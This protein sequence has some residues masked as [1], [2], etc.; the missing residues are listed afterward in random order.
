MYICLR[1]LTELQKEMA[2]SSLFPGKVKTGGPQEAQ[3]QGDKGVLETSLLISEVT[4]HG[5]KNAL[6]MYNSWA[7][8][9]PFVY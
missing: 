7:Q 9:G 2:A 4:G 5:G 3:L 8:L 1:W 6:V